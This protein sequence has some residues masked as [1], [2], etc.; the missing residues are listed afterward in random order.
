MMI[1]WDSA[2]ADPARALALKGAEIIL[3]PIR[4]GIRTLVKARGMENGMFLA[5]S[6]YDDPSFVQDPK[7]EILASTTEQGSAAVATIDLNRRYNWGYNPGNLRLR[8]LK[9]LRFDVPVVRPELAGNCE[10]ADR[11]WGA[12]V[13]LD[14]ARDRPMKAATPQC[15]LPYRQICSGFDKD[16]LRSCAQHLRSGCRPFL[17][18]LLESRN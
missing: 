2:F 13:G 6:S 17:C 11:K 8:F 16:T 15:K 9:E 3:M 14:L 5:T 12:P 10:K 18:L 1:C 4:D 7:G